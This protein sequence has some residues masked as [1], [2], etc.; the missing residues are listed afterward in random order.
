VKDSNFK[1]AVLC[2]SRHCVCSWLQQVAK[3][4]ENQAAEHVVGV[5]FIYGTTGMKRIH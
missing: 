5:E 3:R 2:I 1:A 4:G